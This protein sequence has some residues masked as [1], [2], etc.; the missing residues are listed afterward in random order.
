MPRFTSNGITVE[1]TDNSGEVLAALENAVERG[2]MAC[3]EAAVGY[4]QDLVPVDTG[5]LRG[6][7]TYA[8]DGDDCYI[9]TNVEYAIYVEMGTGIYTPG[10]R[11]TPWAY[12]D[13]LG[14]WHKTHGSKPHPFL[15]PAASN[16]ADEYRNL[17]KES[18]MNA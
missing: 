10:G 17:L 11:Q 1:Y 6:S 12:K 9:G 18:L 4:A 14:K 7:I 13:E 2:L 3:G 8:V 5:R 16:H 15:V